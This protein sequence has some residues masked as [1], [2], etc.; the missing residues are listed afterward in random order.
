MAFS[1]SKVKRRI[2]ATKSWVLCKAWI[3]IQK[4]LRLYNIS[5]SCCWY[6]SLSWSWAPKGIPHSLLVFPEK[7]GENHYR[8]CLLSL[9]KSFNRSSMCL[10]IFS[11]FYVGLYLKKHKNSKIIYLGQLS[12]ANSWIQLKLKPRIRKGT[13]IS[14]T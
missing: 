7:L 1:R 3:A 5:I 12:L 11:F 10:W 4:H 14:P 13:P 8:C 6:Q 2:Q 9:S